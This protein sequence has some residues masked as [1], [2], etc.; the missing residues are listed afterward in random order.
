MR[1]Q[2]IGL[3][4]PTAYVWIAMVAFGG[5]AVE[6][7]IIYPNVFH[8]V[9]ASL[10]EASDFFEVTGPADFFPPM[11]ALTVLAA[12]ASTV[13]AWR[14]PGARWWLL[15]SLGSLVLG[16]FL[17]S[18]LYFWPRNEIMFDE[19]AAVHSTEVL[20]RTA[21]EF[22]NGHW[23]RLAMSGVTAVL[24]FIGF[25]RVYRQTTASEVRTTREVAA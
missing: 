6:T 12:V 17:F 5:I 2:W 10:A 14:V 22:E 9:P 24:A 1:K 3:A 25:L 16:E 8:D 23:V 20:R 13:L 15:G 7:I 18:A 4:V 11:G 21:T 19:G